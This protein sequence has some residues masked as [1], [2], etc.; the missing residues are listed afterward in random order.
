[1]VRDNAREVQDGMLRT[2]LYRFYIRYAQHNMLVKLENEG[3]EV[4]YSAPAF[5]KPAELNEAYL[6]RNVKNKS[7]WVQP[8]WIGEIRDDM[9]HHVSFRLPVNTIG[10]VCFFSDPLM[11]KVKPDFETF[12][13][14][15][16]TKFQEKGEIA[17]KYDQ[18]KELSEQMVNISEK[19]HAI[20]QKWVDISGEELT[21]EEK[22]LSK[23]A[24]YSSVFFGSQLF[25]VQEGKTK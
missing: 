2:P 21:E 11:L 1:M 7:V 18:L 12:S 24:F 19:H 9:E 10:N 25:V 16:L 23:I 17:L 22:L 20:S 13:N 3:N 14:S 5:T 15:I 8:S 4:Y 6:S